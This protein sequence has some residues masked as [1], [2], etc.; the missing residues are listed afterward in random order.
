MKRIVLFV[1]G[2]ALLLST[3][4]WS[5]N[6]G[7]LWKA[8]AASVIIRNLRNDRTAGTAF[9]V[10]ANTLLLVVSVEHVYQSGYS[11]DPLWVVTRPDWQG[12]NVQVIPLPKPARLAHS[13]L[14]VFFSE[15]MPLPPQCRITPLQLFNTPE[16]DDHIYMVGNFFENQFDRLLSGRFVGNWGG[17]G[18]CTPMVGNGPGTS[19]SPVLNGRGHVVGIMTGRDHYSNGRTYDT[20]EPIETFERYREWISEE[21]RRRTRQ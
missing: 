18:H 3:T 10:Q 21:Y 20:Y 2:I 5:Q 11:E 12:V 4:S 1:V 6:S 19:G 15:N 14:R 17:V 16:K 8:Q 13:D 7:L 9:V